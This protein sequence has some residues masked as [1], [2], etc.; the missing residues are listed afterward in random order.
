MT[1]QDIVDKLTATQAKLDDANITDASTIDLQILLLQ[2]QK[3]LAVAAFNPLKDIDS[4]TVA[5]TS[6]LPGLVAQVQTAIDNQKATNAI[7][8]K[9]IG[10]AKLALRGAGVPLPA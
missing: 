7:V 6:Q 1:I 4:I 9:I 8:A 10:T 3:E 2:L 5:D